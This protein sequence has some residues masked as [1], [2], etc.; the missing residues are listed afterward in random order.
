MRRQLG[1]TLLELIM[2]ITIIVFG[3]GWVMNIFKL[4]TG[5]LEVASTLFALRVV[6][7]PLFPLGVVMGFL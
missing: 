1:Y 2:A 3:T 6:G 5:E 7:I 4:A